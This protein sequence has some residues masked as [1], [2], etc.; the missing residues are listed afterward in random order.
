MSSLRPQDRKSL[1]RFTFDGRQCRTQRAGRHP[2]FRPFHAPSSASSASLH[3]S[4]II[5]FLLFSPF[6]FSQFGKNPHQT[7]PS[8]THLNA[9]FTNHPTSVDSKPLT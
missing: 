1:C 5:V 3:N 4:A 7:T 2:H 6:A 8:I 9:T